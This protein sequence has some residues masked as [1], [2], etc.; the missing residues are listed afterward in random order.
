R[1]TML[2]ICQFGAGRIGVI[3]AANV[4]ANP[5][6]RLRY[7]VDVNRAAAEAL[8]ARHGARVVDTDAALADPAVRAVVIASSTAT[9]ADLIERAAAAGKTGF[10]EKPV[11][12]SMA[13][14]ER[15]V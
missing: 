11:D 4:A 12:L 10:C 1:R 7:V 5:E 2:E 6:A 9:H 15:C 3:H 13:R 14:V 8:A